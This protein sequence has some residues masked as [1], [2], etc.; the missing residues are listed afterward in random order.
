MNVFK[1]IENHHLQRLQCQNWAIDQCVPI[2]KNKNSNSEFILLHYFSL[3]FHIFTPFLLE[4]C[5]KII[6]KVTF[7]ERRKSDSLLHY[8]MVHFHWRL[9]AIHTVQCCRYMQNTAIEWVSRDRM[10]WVGLPTDRWW[11][12]GQELRPW[13]APIITCAFVWKKKN[14]Y[15]GRFFLLA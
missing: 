12:V 1:D 3:S 7:K 15:T 6:N 4:F 14:T 9:T 13:Q 5:V 8:D 10:A 11:S 2:Y